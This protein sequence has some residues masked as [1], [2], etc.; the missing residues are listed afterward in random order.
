MI[1]KFICWP[2]GRDLIPLN[3]ILH[4]ILFMMIVWP[5]V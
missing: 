1:D 5:F 4:F 3:A 2:F